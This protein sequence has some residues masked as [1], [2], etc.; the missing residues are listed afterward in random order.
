MKKKKKTLENEM[1]EIV[2]VLSLPLFFCVIILTGINKQMAIDAAFLPVVSSDD[3]RAV[4]LP[5]DPHGNTMLSC[6]SSGFFCPLS[7]SQS[8]LPQPGIHRTYKR[9]EDPNS[10]WEDSYHRYTAVYL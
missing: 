10:L 7:H 4:A 9:E 3:P 6:L 5:Q 1:C 8:T 2:L